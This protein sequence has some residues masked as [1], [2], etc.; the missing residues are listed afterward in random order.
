MSCTCAVLQKGIYKKFNWAYTVSQYIEFLMATTTEIEKSLVEAGKNHLPELKRQIDLW[1]KDR[2]KTLDELEKLA[3]TC[4]F[5]NQMN[6]GIKLG[7]AIV[8]GVS[9]VAGLGLIVVTAG[10]ATPFVIAGGLALGAG[11]LAGGIGVLIADLKIKSNSEEG[12]KKCA[13]I[14]KAEVDTYDK[15]LDILSDIGKKMRK[16]FKVDDWPKVAETLAEILGLS[17]ASAMTSSPTFIALVI[18][19]GI[20]DFEAAVD[21]ADKIIQAAN[22]AAKEAEAVA[23]IAKKAGQMKKAADAAKKAK[24]ARDAAKFA[25]EAKHL[26]NGRKIIDAA[27]KAAKVTGEVAEVVEDVCKAIPTQSWSSWIRMGANLSRQAN[28]VAKE[29]KLAAAA[30]E[31]G[32]KIL[33]PLATGVRVLGKIIVAFTPIFLVLDIADATRAGIMLA[34]GESPTGRYIRGKAKELDEE[35]DYVDIIYKKISGQH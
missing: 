19:K 3:K 21:G 14:C 33:K 28:I 35:R 8:S 10:L 9:T 13:E 11:G 7:G 16:K 34:R 31:E 17:R 6:N 25:E 1:K 12:Q 27:E 23:E 2:Q 24:Q 4:D 18:Q 20:E 30:A 22:K 5:Q 29:A 32:L 15:L 26:W